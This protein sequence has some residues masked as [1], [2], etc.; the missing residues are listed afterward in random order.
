M[1]EARIFGIIVRTMGLSFFVYSLWYLAYAIAN[2]FGVST[3]DYGD[4]SA[5]YLISG[6]LFLFIS[7]YLLKG[8]PHVIKFCY[9]SERA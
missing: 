8:A 6:F 3:S 9:P 2:I 4:K 7:T 1:S 5:S